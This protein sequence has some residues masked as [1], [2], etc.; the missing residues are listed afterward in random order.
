MVD[1]SW[2]DNS[3]AE[4]G[5]VIERSVNGGSFATLDS[6]AANAGKLPRERTGRIDP[7]V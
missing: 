1:L 6:V 3:G 4:T 2:A 5:Y 7:H